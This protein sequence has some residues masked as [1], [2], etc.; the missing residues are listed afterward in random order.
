MRYKKFQISGAVELDDMYTL[1]IT[2]TAIIDG[3]VLKR[4]RV[5]MGELQSVPSIDTY[6]FIKVSPELYQRVDEGK[7]IDARRGN[8]TMYYYVLPE[9]H[10][11]FNFDVIY[12]A[13]ERDGP[14]SMFNSTD[15]RENKARIML[16]KYLPEFVKRNTYE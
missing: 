1:W 2:D 4:K 6:D 13:G 10:P 9:S 5:N 8:A 3:S 16:Q 14:V 12:K 7:Y 11:S 15:E